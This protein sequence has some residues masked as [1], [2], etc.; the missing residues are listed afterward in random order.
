[1]IVRPTFYFICSPIHFFTGYQLERK[2]SS[3]ST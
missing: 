1:V 3:L 2:I